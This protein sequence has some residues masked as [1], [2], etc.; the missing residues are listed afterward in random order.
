M[1][2]HAVAELDLGSPNSSRESFEFLE[3]S[4]VISPQTA[5]KMALMVGFR[6]LLVHQYFRINMVRVCQFIENDLSDFD[7]LV[8][9]L[10]KKLR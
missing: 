7:Q 10:L 8:A 5:S 6:N 3:N 1:A 2:N 4:G 9:E